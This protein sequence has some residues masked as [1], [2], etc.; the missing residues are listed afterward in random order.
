MDLKK[1]EIIFKF[2]SSTA[3]IEVTETVKTYA[4]NDDLQ[5]LLNKNSGFTF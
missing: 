3:F 2:T 1:G 5:N 4:N